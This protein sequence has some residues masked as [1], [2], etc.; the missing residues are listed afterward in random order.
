MTSHSNLG[1]AAG[2]RSQVH[3]FCRRPITCHHTQL[4]IF[5]FKKIR[6]TFISLTL[7]NMW[8]LHS[9]PAGGKF[10]LALKSLIRKTKHAFQSDFHLFLAINTMNQ[11]RSFLLNLYIWHK[12]NLKSV[13]ILQKPHLTISLKR[14]GCLLVKSSSINC[15]ATASP[16]HS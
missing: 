3:V 5:T 1:G 10:Y 13:F 14:R 11:D 6:V 12:A 7:S 15:G 8:W 9:G 16:A 2:G 4:P